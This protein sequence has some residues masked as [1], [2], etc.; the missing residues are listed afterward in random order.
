MLALSYL[1]CREICVPY[2]AVLRLDLPAASAAPGSA[3]YAALIARYGARVPGDGR[4]PAWRSPGRA[5]SPAQSRCWSSRST[6][7]ARCWRPTP[8][9]RGRRG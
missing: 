5:W 1:T 8:S 3:G 7:R 4:A 2:D 6:P 9:S